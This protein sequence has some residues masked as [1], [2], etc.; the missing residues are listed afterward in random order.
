P[1]QLA[2]DT[3]DGRSDIYSLALVAFH[4]LTGKLPFPAETAQESMIMRLTEAPRKL[5]EMRPEVAWT[6][7]V[8]AALDKALQRDVNARFPSAIVRPVAI[9]GAG[10]H[11]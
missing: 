9:L 5:A 10:G 2:G 3:L 1:E 11:G 7:P 4:M 8:Q 6:E